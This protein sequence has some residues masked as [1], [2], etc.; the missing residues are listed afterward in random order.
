MRIGLIGLMNE[1]WGQPVLV[2]NRPSA[3]GI[4]ASGGKERR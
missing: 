2:D 3:G 1:A 4:V